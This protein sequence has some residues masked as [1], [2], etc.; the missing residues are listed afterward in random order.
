MPVSG[1]QKPARWYH[2]VC[3]PVISSP[4]SPFRSLELVLREGTTSFAQ[5]FAVMAYLSLFF[6]VLRPSTQVSGEHGVDGRYSFAL[7]AFS[8]SFFLLELFCCSPFLFEGTIDPSMLVAPVGVLQY[9]RLAVT[10]RLL[11]MPKFKHLSHFRLVNNIIAQHHTQEAI[12]IKFKLST[13]ND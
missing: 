13:S 1:L 8:A 11:F 7:L 12:R 5:L 10:R 9:T 4:P 2:L 3:L 6:G